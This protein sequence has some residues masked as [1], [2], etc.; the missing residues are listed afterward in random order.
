L[1]LLEGRVVRLSRTTALRAWS[2][3]SPVAAVLSSIWL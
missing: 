2:A 1:P 3:G